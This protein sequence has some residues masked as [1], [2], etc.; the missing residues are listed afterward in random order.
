MK[1][2]IPI[3][4]LLLSIQIVY[5]GQYLLVNHVPQT[6]NGRIFELSG[7]GTDAVYVKIDGHSNKV[8]ND[9][10]NFEDGVYIQALEIYDP[11]GNTP[12]QVN[13]EI[14]MSF[15]CGNNNCEEGEKQFCCKD[16]NCTLPGDICME[17][18]CFNA[19]L[20]VCNST[21]DCND[22]IACTNDI[23]SGIPANCTYT[24]VTICVTGDGC[25]PA[26]CNKTIDYVN[27]DWECLPKPVCTKDVDCNDNDETTIDIC[28]SVH[29]TCKFEI[30]VVKGQPVREATAEDTAKAAVQTQPQT[31]GSI[32]QTDETFTQTMDK[33]KSVFFAILLITFFVVLYLIYSKKKEEML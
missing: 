3:I 26:D 7:M 25:C 28:D 27:N 16:C 5:A 30:M 11:Y 15:T 8:I 29:K 17:N 4:I 13:F 20:N 18:K 23:C 21:K 24:P 6:I 1:F 12:L 10:L 14:S 19:A 31:E 9:Q 22:N 2:L 32:S 33:Y